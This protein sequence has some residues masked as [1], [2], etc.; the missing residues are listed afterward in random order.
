MNLYYTNGTWDGTQ[1][2][3]SA[4]RK[5]LRGEGIKAETLD[6]DVPTNKAGLMKFLNDNNVTLSKP[7]DE[8][9]G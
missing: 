4:T 1:A 3:A 8:S 7:N 9:N 6:V 5:R 2:T